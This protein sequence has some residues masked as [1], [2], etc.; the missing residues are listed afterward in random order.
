MRSCLFLFDHYPNYTVSPINTLFDSSFSQTSLPGPTANDLNFIVSEIPQRVF[1]VVWK[2][3][4]ESFI[5]ILFEYKLKHIIYKA[6]KPPT[7]DGKMHFFYLI[8]ILI[9]WLALSNISFDSFLSQKVFL[10]SLPMTSISLLVNYTTII[11][12]IICW[13]FYALCSMF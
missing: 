5:Y 6:L 12:S 13:W 7:H 2:S 3:Y 11:S 4:S 1:H 10:S 8:V 9:I